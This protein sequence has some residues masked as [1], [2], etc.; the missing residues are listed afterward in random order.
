M[1]WKKYTSRKFI[2]TLLTNVMVLFMAFGGNLTDLQAT[3]IIAVVNS[4]Y[5]NANAKAKAVG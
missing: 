5:L 2:V 3:A 4:F 1:D